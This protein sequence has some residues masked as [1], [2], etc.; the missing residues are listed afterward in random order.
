MRNRLRQLLSLAIFGLILAACTQSL[1]VGQEN[2]TD[3]DAD[4]RASDGRGNITGT[5]QT[6]VTPR[7]CQNGDPVAPPFPGILTFNKGGTLSGTS[8]TVPSAFGIWDRQHG[9]SNFAFA[10]ISLRFS[11]TGVFLGTQTVRQTITL[12]AEGNG[13]TSTGTV[14]VLDQNGVVVGSGC[15]SAVGTRF[16]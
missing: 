12:N 1:V 2:K 11:P 9:T 13:F 14:Q 16:E 10:F 4:S 15:A 8:A 6:L 3:D 5:W 7:N